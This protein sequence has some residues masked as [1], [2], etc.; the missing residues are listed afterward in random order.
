MGT[1]DAAL[2]R[3]ASGAA[4]GRSLKAGQAARAQQLA[5]GVVL[6][7]HQKMRVRQ[8][9]ERLWSRSR[10][11]ARAASSRRSG[12]QSS[13]PSHRRADGSWAAGSR[14]CSPPKRHGTPRPAASGGA[15]QY[16][17]G[18]TLPSC[19]PDEQRPGVRRAPSIWPCP[20]RVSLRAERQL[21]Q[22]RRRHGAHGYRAARTVELRCTR[23]DERVRVAEQ[24][25]GEL[26]GQN[27]VF[28]ELHAVFAA[29]KELD[30]HFVLQLRAYARLSAGWEILSSCAAATSVPQRLNADELLQI[31]EFQHIRAPFCGIIPL[32][33]LFGARL[34]ITLSAY[35]LYRNGIVLFALRGLLF[36]QKARE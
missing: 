27:A 7:L 2:H 4:P 1:V 23:A 33:T 25:F 31:V 16:N 24:L 14:A 17:R 20:D 8:A 22:R 13:A 36:T 29:R 5:E 11:S 21:P 6:L 9:F 12:P 18:N 34:S 35:R 19:R 10:G 3:A 15:G 32:R 26:G 30:A 28:V